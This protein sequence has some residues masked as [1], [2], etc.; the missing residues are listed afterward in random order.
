MAV[1]TLTWLY[2]TPPLETMRVFAPGWI[3]YIV[4]RNLVLILLWSGISV[5]PL[6]AST[7]RP[8][9]SLVST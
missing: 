3:A 1:P 6:T 4:L 5:Y 8:M 2:L 7:Q 9:L